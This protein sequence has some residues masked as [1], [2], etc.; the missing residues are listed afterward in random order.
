MKTFKV[1]VTVTS[2]DEFYDSQGK[3]IKDEIESG[4]FQTEV[5]A[6]G[7]KTVETTFEEIK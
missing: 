3:K 6:E 1:I 7:M 4:R 5:K 2:T